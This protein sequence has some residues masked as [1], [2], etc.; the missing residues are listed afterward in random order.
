MGSDLV[1]LARAADFAARR[2]VGQRRKGESAEPYINHL[3]EVAALLALATDGDDPVLVMGGLL[4]DTLE[5]TDARY[6]DLARE[7]GA[8]VAALVKEVTD[9]KSLPKEERKRLQIETT[10]R[11]SRRAKLLKI[12]DKTS[13]LRA[14]VQSPPRGWTEQRLRDYVVWAVAVVRSCRGLNARLEADFDGAY[15][16]ARQRFGA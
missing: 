9:D 3:T 7:F 5:D 11:K 2:H 8:D 15:R 1:Q 10:P 4:H 13:N 14:L 16:E 12:A 6:E